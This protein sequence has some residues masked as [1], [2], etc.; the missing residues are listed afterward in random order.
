MFSG[1]DFYYF[2]DMFEIADYIDA[3]VVGKEWKSRFI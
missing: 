3:M 1:N 2:Y